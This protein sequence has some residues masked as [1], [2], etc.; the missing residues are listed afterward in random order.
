MEQDRGL[1]DSRI[2]IRSEEEIRRIELNRSSI[3]VF[4]AMDEAIPM[5]KTT[6]APRLWTGLVIA[7]VLTQA[8][9]GND[10]Q[11]ENGT[12]HDKSA[13]KPDSSTEAISGSDSPVYQVGPT[14]WT[15][16]RG[17]NGQS[18]PEFIRDLPN[19]WSDESGIKWKAVLPGRGSS[20][21]IVVGDR[22]FVTCFSGYG[23]SATD[24]GLVGHLKYHLICKDR[25]SG[26]TIWQRNISGSRLTQ[27]LN[28]TLIGH[29]F[30]SNTPV[31]D[32]QYVYAFFG[33]TGVF[34]FDMNGNLVWHQNV[35][36][37]YYFFGSSASLVI[38]NNLLIVNASIEN[39]TIYAFDKKNGRGVW[40]V[41]EVDRCYSM[42]V[43]GKAPDGKTEMVIS[44]ED[45][46]RGFDPTTGEELWRCEG[47]HN[48]IIAVPAIK[49]G[50]CYCNGGLER[51]MMAVK[52]GGRG[53]V[54][55]T[56]KVWEV[57]LGGNVGSPIIH[58]ERLFVAND[59]G[60]LECFDIADGKRLGRVRTGTKTRIYA[61][62]MLVGETIFVPLQDEGV[63]LVSADEKMKEVGRNRIASDDHLLHASLAANGDRI[64][65]RTDRYLYCLGQH[66]GPPSTVTYPT[67]AI[68]RNLVD[69]DPRV[70]Y[71][72]RTGRMAPYCYY[73]A[74][75]PKAVINLLLAP[76]K[77]VITEEQALESERIIRERFEPFD[78][79][80]RRQKDAWWSF[81]KGKLNRD[82]LREE[83]K[84]IAEETIQYSGQIRIPVKKLFSQE[85]MDQHLEEAAA[86]RR[87]QQEKEKEE[88]A[89]ND[90]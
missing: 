84:P 67:V 76:Y 25:E 3:P 63:L 55:K 83:L 15:Q 16:Y 26:K 60:I 43:F 90:Q 70:D 40:K 9:C 1:R 54:T 49:D 82:G 44:E 10:T 6:G 2:L 20:S 7:I 61:S 31:T 78:E 85:Q 80:R 69:P 28:D 23:M 47:I 35:G 52:L 48:Y 11:S 4:A 34:A 66:D 51:Q 57:P 65:L 77:S 17:A 39:K 50:I 59:N 89:S 45:W 74:A 18:R 88:A 68:A 41:D 29:G 5:K 79:L 36:V 73:L 37:Q 42:P 81:M 8:G 21:P 13:A 24:R 62:L 58:Q 27:R 14:D 86:W 22:V 56:H 71:D 46:I 72:P 33:A 64:F 30:A 53:D 87:R 19:E 75:D 38:H 32:G 12:G